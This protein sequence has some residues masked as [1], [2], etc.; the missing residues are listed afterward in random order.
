MGIDVNARFIF[1]VPERPRA[2]HG[3]RIGQIEQPYLWNKSL[4]T[5]NVHME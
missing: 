3:N 4:D 1:I 5:E 2:T